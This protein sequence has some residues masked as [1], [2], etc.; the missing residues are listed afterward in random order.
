VCWQWQATQCSNWRKCG[1]GHPS[2]SEPRWQA[3]LIEQSVKQHERLVFT[4]HLLCHYQWDICGWNAST[5]VH[6][7]SW[8]RTALF[9][10]TFS[11]LLKKFPKSVVDFIS[12]MVER[13]LQLHL[14]L[15][16]RMTAC[17]CHV[18]STNAGFLPNV[19]SDVVQISQ[20]LM[21]SMAVLKLGCL[22]LI[23]VE[24]AVKSMAVIIE[25]C[26]WDNTLPVMHWSAGLT[27]VF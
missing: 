6:T 4:N 20:S 22:E 3:G 2:D 1:P 10:W 18:M 21:V 16:L 12:F 14:H 13:S 15:M 24:P 17:M 8:T 9:V 7:S 19:C 25:M 5:D 27:F 26:C 11:L 23:F